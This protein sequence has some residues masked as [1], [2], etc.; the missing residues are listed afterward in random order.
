MHLT[1]LFL[2]TPWLQIPDFGST[3]SWRWSPLPLVLDQLD[4]PPTPMPP[5]IAVTL[6]TSHSWISCPTHFILDPEL[7]EKCRVQSVSGS[8][9]SDSLWL[10]GLGPARLL[11]P[12]NFPGKNSGVGSHSLLQGIFLTQGLNSDPLQ[13]KQISLPSGSPGKPELV[14]LYGLSTHSLEASQM[15]AHHPCKLHNSSSRIE[16]YHFFYQD[17]MGKMWESF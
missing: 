7:V 16:S 10:H 15:H 12:F 11:C 8:A 3:H 5:A 14:E 4:W 9:M 1:Q 6:E 2:L 13:C 17:R